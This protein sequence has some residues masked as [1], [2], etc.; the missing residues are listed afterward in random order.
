[1]GL[2][3]DGVEGRISTATIFMRET[4]RRR[5]GETRWPHRVYGTYRSEVT[6]VR[7]FGARAVR[8]VTSSAI[9]VDC[10]HP[11]LNCDNRVG[12]VERS[13]THEDRGGTRHSG[14]HLRLAGGLHPPYKRLRVRSRNGHGVV[15]VDRAFASSA[16]TPC[17]SAAQIA[18]M[19]S[20]SP[21]PS[22]T[23]GL[24]RLA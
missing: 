10:T 20:S 11:T 2:S 15:A 3:S 23:A 5:V 7:H 6:G 13:A 4:A 19:A 14:D 12:W 22:G 8:K 21:R 16:T 18:R 17:E 1:M 24:G 9:L